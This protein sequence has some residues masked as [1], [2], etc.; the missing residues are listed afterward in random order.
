MPHVVTASAF[1]GVLVDAYADLDWVNLTTSSNIAL[2]G[3][4]R[5]QSIAG[6][7][8][9]WRNVPNGSW[10]FDQSFPVVG[11]TKAVSAINVGGEEGFDAA[12]A[13]GETGSDFIISQS[14]AMLLTGFY[15]E[16]T[17]AANA[18]KF[19]MY[20][21]TSSGSVSFSIHYSLDVDIEDIYNNGDDEYGRARVGARLWGTSWDGSAWSPWAIL[22]GT[23]SSQEMIGDG[24]LTDGV[25]TINYT[26]TANTYIM[27][28]AQADTIASVKNP[29]PVPPSV[30]ML[31]TGC[32]SLF[33]MKR[34]KN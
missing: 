9:L 6:T 7:A 22:P 16:Y 29:V 32:T 2:Y 8:P 24:A 4:A 25:L 21:V 33:F 31:L 14:T 11:N 18:Q 27:F 5:D 15:G 1:D 28:H 20:S 10:V 34:R 17:A 3:S 12:Y 23:Y 26:A 30:L 19:Q 13:I